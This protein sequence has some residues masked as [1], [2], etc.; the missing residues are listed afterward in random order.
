MPGGSTTGRKITSDYAD[1]ST[2]NGYNDAA[3]LSR[4]FFRSN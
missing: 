3:V 4:I 1:K 2:S